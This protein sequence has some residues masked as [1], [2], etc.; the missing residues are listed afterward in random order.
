VVL[1]GSCAREDY[2][3]ESDIDLLVLLDVV[4][5]KLPEARSKMRPMAGKLIIILNK[6]MGW[7]GYHLSEYE[8]YH[9][10][11]QLW[12]D[13]EFNEAVPMWD[14]DL[15]DSS[16]T[17]INEYMEQQEW[18]TYTYDFGDDWQHRVTIEKIIEDY[19]NNC[20]Q[21]NKYRGDCP[22]EDCGGIDGYY[23]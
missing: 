16:K 21:V 2:D 1:Y 6:I 9:L 14:F 15:L 7:S 23:E 17:F 22:M 13:N 18:F 12:E 11:L 8:F 4:P 10:Q 20:P 5:T 3:D 19:P